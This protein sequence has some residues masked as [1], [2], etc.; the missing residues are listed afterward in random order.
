VLLPCDGVKGD[1]KESREGANAK[2]GRRECSL[3]DARWGCDVCGCSCED[4]WSGPVVSRSH[5]STSPVKNVRASR[6]SADRAKAKALCCLL[7][8]THR[9]TR[10]ARRK[11]KEPRKHRINSH[12][13]TRDASGHVGS[14]RAGGLQPILFA[15]KRQRPRAAPAQTH[16]GFQA[17]S[18][19]REQ[20]LAIG[21][22]E[23]K[24]RCSVENH[25]DTTWPRRRESCDFV[26][27]L[28]AVNMVLA[29]VQ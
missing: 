17:T 29:L 16:T 10:E 15:Q 13:S 7:A 18:S 21:E 28:L 20:P 14:L 11:S 27:N 1:G 8:T 3:R 5:A 19:K 23:K 4:V 24:H 22:N 2:V 26:A 12:G 9:P 25:H 6:L